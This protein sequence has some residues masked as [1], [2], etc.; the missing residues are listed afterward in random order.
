MQKVVFYFFSSLLL[1][2][3]LVLHGAIPFLLA[4]TLGQ[5]LWTAGFAQSF[6]NGTFHTI[7]AHNFGF[8]SPA[9]MMFGLSGGWLTG[10]FIKLGLHPIDA[11]SM[12]AA[13]WLTVAFIGGYRFA[14]FFSVPPYLALLSSL[15]W[16]CSPVIFYHRS[17]SM[18]SF[19]IAL[20]P[21]YFLATVIVFSEKNIL[22][23]KNYL[24]IIFI[25]IYYLLVCNIAVFMDGYTFMMFAVGSTIY[26]GTFFIFNLRKIS[27]NSLLCILIHFLSFTVAYFLYKKYIFNIEL[28]SSPLDFFRSFG[29]D[30]SFL[31]QPTRGVHWLPD[32]LGLSYIRSGRIFFGDASVWTTSYCAPIILGGVWAIFNVKKRRAIVLAFSFIALFA[33]YMSL[34][35]SLKF[36]SL[37]P[38]GISTGLMSE[39]YTISPT[40]SAFLSKNIPGFKNMRACYRWIALA[41]FAL[42]GLITLALDNTSKKN[43]TITALIIFII[44]M[45]YLPNISKD[46]R[47]SRNNYLSAH[48]ID[49]DILFDMKQ[50]I[51]PNKVVV[52]LPWRNDFLVNYLAARLS[53]KTFN[54]GGDKNFNYARNNWPTIMKK[55]KMAKIDKD[56][57]QRVEKLLEQKIVDIVV[58]P[59]ID[60][61]WAAHKWPYPI[62]FKTI[63][64]P[65]IDFLQKTGLFHINV[66]KYYAIIRLK[67]TS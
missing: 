27:F 46:F 24:E 40:G 49:A 48:K 55:F 3:V 50:T 60:M 31:I 4:P 34:G 43:L 28:P 21:F 42:W 22:R 26:I 53:I 54:V 33:F 30:I 56:F 8:P 29:V 37:R 19:G 51:P 58:L 20:L 11:Y 6:A 45:L 12:M 36:N 16:M 63:L 44:V 9:P 10:V 67:S 35:P 5:T 32:L 23:T 59:F 14:R 1:S 7:Y 38:E 61:L 47:G 52:F 18:L 65:T 39:K 41:S 57:P 66:K 15:C 64:L 62:E 17:Y 13:F 2:G 25:F